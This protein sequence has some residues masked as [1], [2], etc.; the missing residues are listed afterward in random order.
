MREEFKASA[1]APREPRKTGAF[2]RQPRV[3]L[4]AAVALAV[5]AGLIA[6]AVIGSGGNSSPGTQR[7]TP[8][9]AGTGPV[10]VSPSGL[11]TMSST[12]KQ[13]IYWAGARRGYTYELTRTSDAKIFVRYLP[14]GVK[15][16]AKGA[17]YLIVATYPFPNALNGLKAVSKGRT[18]PISGNGIAVVDGS[19][20]KS[21]H[22]AFPGV[23]YQVE[24]YDPKPATALSVAT[25]GDVRPVR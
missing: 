5:A 18:I 16:G 13:P 8:A 15:V 1:D 24:V 3:R 25:S 20:P 19:Y 10:A 23:D 2:L 11:R 4:G 7:S 21:V 17:N 14:P 6:W 22:L 12:L 9:V